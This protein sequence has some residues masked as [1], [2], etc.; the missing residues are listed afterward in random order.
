MDIGT[1]LLLIAVGAGLVDIAILLAGPRIENYEFLSLIMAGMGSLASIGAVVWMGGLIFGN[2]F[3]YEYV[4]LT[5]K[6]EASWFLKI[7]ALW[8]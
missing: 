7:S 6:I 8:A 3:Q 1:M 2:Q 5:T 4:F